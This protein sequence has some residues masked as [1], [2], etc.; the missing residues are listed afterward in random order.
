MLNALARFTDFLAGILAA[1]S[2]MNAE[3]DQLLLVHFDTNEMSLEM[4]EGSLVHLEEARV[5]FHT[6]ILC[7]NQSNQKF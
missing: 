3:L 4:T 5:P 2:N 6:L 1:F 7:R